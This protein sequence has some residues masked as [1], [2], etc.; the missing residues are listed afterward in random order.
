MSGLAAG[1]F[2]IHQQVEFVAPPDRVFDGLLDVSAWWSHHFKPPDRS[3]E[4]RLILE[5]RLG[6]AFKQEWGGGEG[7][8]FGVIT[9]FKRPEVIRLAG[10][11]GMKGAISSVYEWRL[12]PAGAHTRF[13]LHHAASGLMDP[14][15]RESH[16]KGWRELWEHL[17]AFVERGERIR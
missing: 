6:G 2:E 9:F 13:F 15:E 4:V 12:E 7:A 16:D 14:G 3:R 17:Q 10:P 1:S 5:P 8:L 11:L